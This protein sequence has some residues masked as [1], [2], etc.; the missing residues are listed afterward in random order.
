MKNKVLLT[1]GQGFTGLYVSQALVGAGFDVFNLDL[2]ARGPKDVVGD[3]LNKESLCAAVRQVQPDY[4]IHLA[5]IAHVDHSNDAD[6]YAVNVA[7]TLNLLAAIRQEKKDIL[8]IVLASSANVYGNPTVEVVHEGVPAAPLNHYAMSKLAMEMLSCTQFAEDLPLVFT[9]PFNYTGVGQASSFL[10]PKIVTH[11]KQKKS[12]IELGNT[13]VV[14]EF[15]DVRTVA[16]VYCDILKYAPAG[17]TVNICSGSGYALLDVIKMCEEL[18]GFSIDVQI[19]P[20]FV[21]QNELKTLIGS[22]DLLLKIAPGLRFI[23]LNETLAWMLK[24]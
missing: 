14:R 4:L 22:P 19:N 6:F 5:A 15:N 16:H 21:R 9:R 10:I 11:F 7:G 8:K 20:K 18:M 13:D 23:P 2:V 24:E 1:G 3:L 17:S 12:F